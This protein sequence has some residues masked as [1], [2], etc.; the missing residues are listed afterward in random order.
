M[1]KYSIHLRYQYF[2]LVFLLLQLVS[3]QTG[4]TNS[5]ASNLPTTQTANF[6]SV[7]NNSPTVSAKMGGFHI[8]LIYSDNGKPVRRQNIY[9]AEMLPVTGGQGGVSVPALDMK[10]APKAESTDQ[11]DVVISMIPP[12]KYALSLLTPE[13]AILLTDAAANKEIT[14][15]VAAGHVTELGDHKVILNSSLLEPVP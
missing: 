14:F 12:G 7:G 1:K 13:G 11:G 2:L 3:C 4:Q 10:T 8:R 15:D 6:T 9:L 5:P